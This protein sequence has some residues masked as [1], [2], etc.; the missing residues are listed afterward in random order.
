MGMD[1]ARTR[2][3]SILK[4]TRRASRRTRTLWWSRPGSISKRGDRKEYAMKYRK[5]LLSL[6][7]LA[8]GSIIF[9]AT[10]SLADDIKIIANSTVNVD[11]ISLA[12]LK[13][14]FLEERS[15][16]GS[17]HVEPVLQ[18][19]GPAH[20]AF[21]QEYLGMSDD[22]LQAYYRALVFTGRG[23]MPKVLGSDAEVVAYVARTR[24]AIGIVS[25][26]TRAE[27]VK[28]LALEL[29]NSGAARKLITRVEPD[30]PETL[31]RLNIGGTVRLRVSISPK[32][33][34]EQV[35]L[36]GGNPILGESAALAVK[37]WVY[38]AAK[39]QTVTEVTLWFD[40]R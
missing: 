18:K 7:L 15:S 20:E 12:E 14:V 25:S 21:L 8:A 36:L 1:S 31:K 29:P 9:G 3:A 19:D 37:K 30:Y 11:T 17:T 39:S 4:T 10:S 26:A 13:A 38:A 28:T 40:G 35:E 6:F 16:I 5:I 22:N 33:T 2:T 27:G 32:G 34:V 23:S 24:G